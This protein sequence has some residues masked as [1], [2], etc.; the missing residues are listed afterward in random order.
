[1]GRKCAA[2]GCRGDFK[3]EPYSYVV[4]FPDK[5]TDQNSWDSWID[6]MPNDRRTLEK[7]KKHMV[8]SPP[9]IVHL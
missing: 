2:F 8:L 4:K 6:V 9:L 1:M 3:G 5:E 7:I